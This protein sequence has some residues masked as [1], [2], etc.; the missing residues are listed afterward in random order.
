MAYVRTVWVDNSAPALEAAK[1]N[2]IEEGIESLDIALGTAQ[3]D[4]QQNTTDINTLGTGIDTLSASVA[5]INTLLTNPIVIRKGT[6]SGSWSPTLT[7]TFSVSTPSD[8][9][10]VIEVNQPSRTVNNGYTVTLYGT[11]QPD[12]NTINFVSTDNALPVNATYSIIG[13]KKVFSDY[14]VVNQ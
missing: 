7:S 1:L 8:Y 3:D 4:I 10:W 5:D 12:G 14:A 13:I 11:L 2:N 9:Y 6:F